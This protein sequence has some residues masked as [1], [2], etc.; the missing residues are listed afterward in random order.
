MSQH[1]V[2]KVA[3]KLNSLFNTERESYEKLWS[4]I[5]IF[6][7]Y[8]SLRERK[9]YD[10]VKTA[11]MYPLTNGKTVTLDEYLENAKEK[12]EKTVYYATDKSVQAQYISMLENEGIEIA[13]LD[14]GLDNQFMSLV[15]QDQ[16]VNFLRVDA[17][18][19]D[20]L[21]GDGEKYES[22]ALTKLFTDIGG[23]KLKVKYEP[24]KDTSLPAVLTVSEE[25][26]RF[27]EMMKLYGM[28]A[29][30]MPA[31]QGELVLNSNCEMIRRLGEKAESDD[32]SVK[33]SAH[34]AAKQIYGLA[35][36]GQRQLTA[37][38]LKSFLAD[39]FNILGK[40]I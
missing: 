37:D 30:E 16:G 8:G 29:G 24:L 3:D 28:G 26:R 33:E 13:Y 20:A 9:F 2:K 23:E 17:G 14:K 19:A 39:S 21:K 32:E 11:V 34:T 7:E 12:H 1:I 25:E 27:G 22:E 18:V 35:L 5:K 38:E 40:I 6:V 36:I 4:D 31:P 10:R 15:E